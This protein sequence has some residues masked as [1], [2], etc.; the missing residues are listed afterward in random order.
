MRPLQMF[1]SWPWELAGSSNIQVTFLLHLCDTSRIRKVQCSEA[2]RFPMHHMW[3]NMKTETNRRS[4][5]KNGLSAAGIA[6]AGIGFLAN[7]SSLLAD[8]GPQRSGHL[9]RGGAL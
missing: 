8:Q 2:W 4:F 1:S 6:T 9:S 3:N 7:G 5:V